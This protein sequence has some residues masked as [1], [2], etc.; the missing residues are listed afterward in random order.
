MFRQCP[1]TYVECEFSDT[2]CDAKVYR[3]DLASHLTD[4][5]VTHMSLLV[6]ENRN[7][8]RQLQ[9]Q[10]VENG[11]LI[12]RFNKQEE[13][14]LVE[15]KAQKE[16]MASLE[17][18]LQKLCDVVHQQERIAVDPALRLPPFD[19]VCPAHF[20]E[21]R[22]SWAS[23]PFLV[24]IGQCKMLLRLHVSFASRMMI[25]VEPV[26]NSSPAKPATQPKFKMTVLFGSQNCFYNTRTYKCCANDKVDMGI[27][28]VSSESGYIKNDCVIF[29]IADAKEV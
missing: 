11:E 26:E 21:E 17:T 7:L 4:N 16:K 3:K 14:S 9:K 8:K 2:G 19:I 24:L 22:R 29:C 20:C 6:A 27:N 13:K 5:L 15:N 12:K 28:Y 18:Q 25:S 1:L 10:V 23:E